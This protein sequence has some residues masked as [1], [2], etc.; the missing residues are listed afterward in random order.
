MDERDATGFGL[1][2][3]MAAAVPVLAYGGGAAVEA[4]GGAGIA[5]T[6]KRFGVLAELVVRLATDTFNSPVLSSSGSVTAGSAARRS[7]LR[8]RSA[9]SRGLKGFVR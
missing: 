6:E 5:F 8:T 3:A 4:L 2:E 7:T 1:L 9:S